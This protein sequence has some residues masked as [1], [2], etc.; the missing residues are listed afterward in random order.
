M[1]CKPLVSI[2]IPTVPDR[3]KELMRAIKSIAAQTYKNIE[4]IIVCDDTITSPAACNQGLRRAKGKYIAFLGD[5]DI[6]SSKDKIKKQVAIMESKPYCELCVSW[7]KDNRF[8][9]QRISKARM[10]ANHED[11]LKAFNYSSGSTY[12]IRK[13]SILPEIFQ[14]FDETLLSGQ[15]YDLALRLTTS[16]KYA[17]C[18]E[19]VLVEQFSTPGQISTNWYKK[20]RG[21][22]QLAQKHGREYAPVDW[23]KVLGL[24]GLYSLGYIINVRIYKLITHVK[25]MYE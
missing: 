20:I 1:T 19:E 21:I 17:Y 2:I 3:E 13:E 23:L 11:L 9:M 14:T 7:S 15:E 25:E 4:L 5:D 24:L 6:Y 18:I 12:M 22:W 8:G 10:V 16:W